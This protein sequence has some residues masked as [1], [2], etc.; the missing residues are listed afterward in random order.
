MKRLFKRKQS[1]TQPIILRGDGFVHP[2]SNIANEI[3]RIRWMCRRH[4]KNRQPTLQFDIPIY[5]PE[6]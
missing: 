3:R 5:K 4:A 2:N 1:R 6:E